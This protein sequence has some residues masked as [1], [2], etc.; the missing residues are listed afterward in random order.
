MPPSQG[1]PSLA[2]WFGGETPAHTARDGASRAGR[3]QTFRKETSSWVIEVSGE[4][5][6]LRPYWTYS[7][8]EA[9]KTGIDSPVHVG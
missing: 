7:M 8:L 1:G 6:A 5:G 4:A 2:L 9:R 3:L